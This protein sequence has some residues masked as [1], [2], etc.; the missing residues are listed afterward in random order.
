MMRRRGISLVE[1]MVVVAIIL[2]VL[3]IVVTVMSKVWRVV[4]SFKN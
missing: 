2:I 3:L 4:E 1:L